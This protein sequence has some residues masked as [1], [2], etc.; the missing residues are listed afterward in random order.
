M[1]C[2][3]S[4]AEIVD[5]KGST[6]G[7]TLYLLPKGQ[8]YLQEDQGGRGE[9]YSGRKLTLVDWLH[10]V[11]GVFLLSPNSSPTPTPYD[12]KVVKLGVAI[13][14]SKTGGINRLK[15]FLLK[16]TSLICFQFLTAFWINGH[17]GEYLNPPRISNTSTVGTMH[18]I[19]FP[20]M[21]SS[22]DRV[23][24]RRLSFTYTRRVVTK[25]PRA[26]FSCKLQWSSLTARH[27]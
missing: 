7:Y 19:S 20:M 4:C 3:G 23:S 22:R 13:T 12:S 25:W 8:L 2:G 6:C 27:G 15:A 14:S 17:V 21:K 5:G 1:Q 11:R 18:S 9:R 16:C 10:A 24:G 26:G